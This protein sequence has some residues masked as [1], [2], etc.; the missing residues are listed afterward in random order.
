MWTE[1]LERRSHGASFHSVAASEGLDDPYDANVLATKHLDAYLCA[2]VTRLRAQQVAELDREWVRVWPEVI[3]GSKPN[4]TRFA[5]AI[6]ILRG[7]ARIRGLYVAK[8]VVELEHPFEPRR[9]GD[10][11]RRRCCGTTR[12][13]S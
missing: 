3:V 7:R 4:P 10:P 11:D 1:C 12:R 8:P 6:Q 9:W 13:V 2:A 5:D